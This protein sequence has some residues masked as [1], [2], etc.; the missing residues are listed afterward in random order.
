MGGLRVSIISEEGGLGQKST[1]G[2]MAGSLICLSSLLNTAGAMKSSLPHAWASYLSAPVESPWPCFS[3]HARKE[4]PSISWVKEVE[5]WGSEG[6][7]FF[8]PPTFYRN[9]ILPPIP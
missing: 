5:A 6:A 3:C 1:F 8:I 4:S 7:A 2:R 9:A